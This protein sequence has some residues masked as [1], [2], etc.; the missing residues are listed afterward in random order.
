M[1]TSP[2]RIGS[3]ALNTWARAAGEDQPP[4]RTF[5]VVPSVFS[6]HFYGVV[7]M[8]RL[9]ELSVGTP[10]GLIVVM[11]LGLTWPPPHFSDSAAGCKG[12]SREE[13]GRINVCSRISLP[14]EV[15]SP[16]AAT[17]FTAI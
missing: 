4:M 16:H 15:D 10:A 1:R 11:M 3:S 14:L 8:D 7:A 12:E 6:S 13:A 5:P 9:L 2:T 17:Y